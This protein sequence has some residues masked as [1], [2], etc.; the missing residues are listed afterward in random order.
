MFSLSQLSSTLNHDV[1]EE[2][3]ESSALA[4]E[5]LRYIYEISEW[6]LQDCSYPPFSSPLSPALF[7][8]PLILVLVFHRPSFAFTRIFKAVL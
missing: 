7:L 2:A 1:P 5:V 6:V 4:M 8:E 3:I